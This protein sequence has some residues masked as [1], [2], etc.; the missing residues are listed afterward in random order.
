MNPDYIIED[1]SVDKSFTGI[2]SR[3]ICRLHYA[4]PLVKINIMISS[5]NKRKN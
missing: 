2:L 1:F 3:L 4:P 5:I